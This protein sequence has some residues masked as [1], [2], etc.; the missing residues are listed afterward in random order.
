MKKL[1]VLAALLITSAAQGLIVY[2]SVNTSAPADCPFWDNV[3]NFNG[4]SGIYIGEGWVLTANHVGAPASVSIQGQPYSLQAGTSQ[5][6][7]GR[8]V[9]LFRVA[10]W[11]AITLPSINITPGW[12]HDP[13]TGNPI[14][15]SALATVIGYGVGKGTAVTGGWAWNGTSQKQ[16]GLMPIQTSAND[17]LITHYFNRTLGPN[18]AAATMGDS[19]G[20][21]FY[22][23]ASGWH[24]AGIMT[25]VS[26]MGGGYSYY[27]RSTSP[28]EQPG[29]TLSQRLAG[30]NGAEIYKI[31]GIWGLE[32]S[33]Y[34][35][36]SWSGSP[37]TS[38]RVI[39]SNSAAYNGSSYSSTAAL[40]DVSGTPTIENTSIGSLVLRANSSTT[41]SGNTSI[42]NLSLEAGTSLHFENATASVEN[43]GATQYS[44]Q[45]ASSNTLDIQST[46][47]TISFQTTGI[48][49]RNLS[50][51]N[52]SLTA[53][54]SLVENLTVKP[55]TSIHN[56]DAFSMTV[57]GTGVTSWSYSSMIVSNSVTI[58]A[59]AELSTINFRP[60][61]T[62][63]LLVNGTLRI[64]GPGS[65]TL[66]ANKIT[67][68]DDS[69]I[70]F[71]LGSTGGGWLSSGNRFA[72][73][74]IVGTDILLLKGTLDILASNL[75]SQNA[76]YT[77]FRSTTQN[78][79]DIQF[80]NLSPEG[81]LSTEF[82]SFLISSNW[83]GQYSTI[84][85]SNFAAIPEP[86]TLLSLLAGGSILLL[87]NR[88]RRQK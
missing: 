10:N 73:A 41:I 62:A 38:S 17:S 32:S 3:L 12:D 85:A 5:Q 83:D 66:Y 54:S 7:S 33:S 69:Q 50:L 35:G 6:I 40:I 2:D 64:E 63:S 27:D 15:G 70:K 59:G 39:L 58:E 67:L 48:K 24:L 1:V 31:T 29:Y 87:T 77:L 79:F 22:Q 72:T 37:T 36:S 18:M 11:N 78:A 8:D 26:E 61:N 76:V 80:S 16:W 21:V 42:Q 9:R 19:G 4:A 55:G 71:N 65:A 47:S 20:G 43:F 84:T 60:Q 51:E 23:D 46:N 75:A 68:T 57:L 82:G 44:T 49:I 13:I 56:N 81:I 52:T 28:G 25:N 88:V 45:T 30:T 34:N 53:Q 14:E 86:S 74:D